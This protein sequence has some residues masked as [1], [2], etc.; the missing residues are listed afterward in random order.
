M[1]TKYR[2]NSDQ[3]AMNSDHIANKIATKE[4]TNRFQIVTN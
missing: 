3:T 4:R 2:L 1:E